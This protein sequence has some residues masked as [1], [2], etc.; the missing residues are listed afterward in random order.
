MKNELQTKQPELNHSEKFMNLVMREFGSNV[1]GEIQIT[2]YQRRLA[3]GYFI[4]IDR[5]LKTTEEARLKKGNTN[6]LSCN[7]S[8]VNTTDLALDVVH[9]ASM[10]LDMMQ[11]NHLFPVPYKNNKTNKYDITLMP[12]YNGIRYIAEKYAVEVPKS[13]TIELVYS[14]DKFTPYKKD[15]VHTTET[16]KFEITDAFDRG[17]I[18]GGFGYIEYSDNKK[19]KLVFMSRKDILKR[20]PTYASTEFWGGEKPIWENGKKTDKTEMVEGYFDEMARKTLIRE[21]YSAKHMPRDPQKIDDNY[22]YLK[23]REEQYALIAVESEVTENAN[24]IDI[25]DADIVPVD[26]DGVIAE[27]SANR[28]VPEQ[29]HESG[30]NSEGEQIPLTP[31]F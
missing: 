22:Q 30:D 6:N 3:Q 20:K 5:A 1:A 11:D 10:G 18:V 29:P 23:A 15:M 12:G 26:E 2:E 31:N 9:Y 27:S 16:Y 24:V 14:N 17:H 19:N 28:D 4:I 25:D 8:T 13:V 7:W 21:V